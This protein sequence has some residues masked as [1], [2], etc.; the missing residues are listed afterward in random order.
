MLEYLKLAA[1]GAMVG[2]ITILVLVFIS[3]IVDIWTK[4]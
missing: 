2:G 4:K 3:V 1:I